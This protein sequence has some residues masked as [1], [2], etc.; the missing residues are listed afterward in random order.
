MSPPIRD[1]S[2]SSIGSIRLGDGTEI[3]EV[4]TGAGDVLFSGA[5]VIDSMEDQDKAEYFDFFQ[6]SNVQVSTAR[7]SDGSAS[8]EWVG[9]KASIYSNSGLE[10][11]PVRGDTIRHDYFQATDGAASGFDFGG[12]NPQNSYG[13]FVD[14]NG[15]LELRRDTRNNGGS[16]QVLAISPISPP[17]GEFLTVEIVWGTPTITA[18]VRDASGTTLATVSADDSFFDSGGIG[19]SGDAGHFVD[20]ARIV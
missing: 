11:Y 9:G 1:G 20:F 15:K 12:D 5:D 6:G 16:I 7:A 17:T 19:W 18:E 13:V 3:S 8:F 10:N 2:G 4:R 14:L